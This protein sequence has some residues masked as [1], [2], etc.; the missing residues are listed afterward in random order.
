MADCVFGITGKDFVI[1]G[2]DLSAARSII[3]IQDED[4]KL[5]QLTNNQIL[6]VSGEN[7]DR[8]A[9]SKLIF[10]ELEYYYYRYNNR[11]TTDEVANYTRYITIN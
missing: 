6:A 7:T 3:K 5:T 2:S 9:F 11:L 1:I 10:G 8:T 4:Y